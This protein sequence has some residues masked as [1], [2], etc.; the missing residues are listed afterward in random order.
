MTNIPGNI[1]VTE[2]KRMSMEEESVPFSMY[3]SQSLSKPDFASQDGSVS[4]AHKGTLIHYV[5]QKID[6]LRSSVDEIQ[7][8]IDVMCERGQITP[9]EHMAVKAEDISAFIN[10]DLG[11]EIVAHY[12]SFCR[13]YSFKYLMNAD[14]IYPGAED[15]DIIIQGVIDAFFV[16][17]DG[18]IVLIDYKTDKI[19]ENEEKT[20]R[21]YEAQ[22]KYYAIAIEKILK[23]EVESKYIHLFEAGKTIK[24]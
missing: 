16:N 14:E 7:H 20:A 6:F 13:E 23:K 12:D 21:K 15:D 19:V 17:D 9:Q 22:L 18:K 24:M 2:L 3:G 8:Q 10:S 5:M 4:G 1:S 11:R